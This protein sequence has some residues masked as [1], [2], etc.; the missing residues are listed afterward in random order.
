VSELTNRPG[1]PVRRPDRRHTA[2]VLDIRNIIG[3]LLGT[4]GVILLAMGLLGDPE[5]EKTGGVNAN[6]WAGLALLVVGLAFLVWAKA[7]P[8]VVPKSDPADGQS[9]STDE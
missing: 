9:G 4:Y 8:V 2:G 6:A 5:T 7:R 3:G 1:R